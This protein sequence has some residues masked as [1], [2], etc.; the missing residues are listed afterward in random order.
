M[1][2]ITPFIYYILIFGSFASFG[3][4]MVLFY[5]EL[6]FTGAQI[7][8]IAGITP[9]IMLF[10][11]PFWTGIADRN[12]SHR[13]VMSLALLV[14]AM[15]ISLFP[16]FRTY[17]PIL[18]LA[19]GMQIFFSPISAL[20]DSATMYMLGDQRDQYGRVRLGGTI[21]FGAAAWIAGSVVEN[22]GLRIAFWIGASLM[23]A[24]FLVSQKMV[25]DPTP[26]NKD[27]QRDLRKLLTNPS[28]LIF[29]LLAFAGGIG[30]AATNTYLLPF[31]AELGAGESL[32]GIIITVGTVFEFPVL[33]FGSRLV[34]RFTPYRLFILGLLVTGGRFLLF[35]FSTSPTWIIV[36]Q[37]FAGFTFGAMWLAG[38]AHAYASAPPG[39]TASA[40][41]MLSAMVF[42]IGAAVGNFSGGLLLEALGGRGMYL[43]LGTAILA[44]VALGVV[45]G[46]RVSVTG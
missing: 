44:I 14:T 15:V 29:L 38:V 8:L 26:P 9:L 6:G 27:N 18:L 43:T 33:F 11:A 37:I 28:W 4:F 10:A 25:H 42:G 17:L 31:L 3:P 34:R 41:G 20:A 45:L 30:T 24:A 46:K 12:R 2:K 35:G 32:M 1:K 36:L 23:L 7:G 22:H 5:Q 39:Y 13:L 21:G 40:Q 19:I 16:F